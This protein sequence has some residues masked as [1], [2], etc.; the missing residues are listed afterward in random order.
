M[1]IDKY[2][3]YFGFDV[4]LNIFKASFFMRDGLV[5]LKFSPLVAL[6]SNT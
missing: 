6:S 3:F 2:L 4:I 1:Y 5:S